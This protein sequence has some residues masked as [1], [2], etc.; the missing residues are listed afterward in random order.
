MFFG[1][2]L[3]KHDSFKNIL[4]IGYEFET[5]DLAKLSLSDG[6]LVNSSITARGM[7]KKI[8]YSSASKADDNNYELID[9]DRDLYYTEYYDEYDGV[10][11]DYVFMN[12]TNDVGSSN[13]DTM[14]NKLCKKYDDDSIKNDI[15]VFKSENG[16]IQH[17]I[18]FDSFLSNL[19][20]SIFS[21]V[22]YLVTYLKIKKTTN[23]ILET[24]LNACNRIFT[25][26]RGIKKIP[27]DLFM[28]DPENGNDIKIGHM[29]KRILYHKPNTNL[30]YLQTHDSDVFFKE[31]SIG[32]VQF[33]PQMTFR[34]NIKHVI[35]IMKDI[36]HNSDLNR[37]KRTKN[38][39]NREHNAISDIESCLESLF[40]TYNE[41][42]KTTK[43]KKISKVLKNQIFGYLF[44]IFYKIYMYINSYIHS[45]MTAD[46]NYF[47]NYLSFSA[48]HNNFMFYEKIKKLMYPSFKENTVSTI[49]ALLNQPK[50][51][52]KFIYTSRSIRNAL[53]TV[54]TLG[55]EEYG[56]PSV[57]YISYFHHF[58]KFSEEEENSFTDED[59]FIKADIDIYSTKFKMPEDGSIIIENRLFS[60]EL[61]AFANDNVNIYAS[62]AFSLNNLKNIY[63]KLINTHKVDDLSKKE[64][65]PNTL[66]FVNKCKSG[67]YRNDDFVCK[68]KKTTK[69]THTKK[70]PTK[71]TTTRKNIK[72]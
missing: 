27:G 68:P 4:S 56:N 64:I 42:T 8:K 3:N 17:N 58:E 57:S 51:V 1:G 44:M 12:I 59:W 45:D 22:E 16:E 65:N 25:H 30:Y 11:N 2:D 31:N 49:I 9:E 47:K 67:H 34:A 35:S 21:G 20:C 55:D 72:V 37:I 60:T 19:N 14:L 23:I 5:H 50:I 18:V 69:K 48:R 24:F 62:G 36:V 71:K 10:A 15:Y 6:V 61:T 28:R 70:N 13:F 33:Q 32:N 38:Q 63:R 26:I 52:G 29:D 7:T 43:N 66:N 40:E 46:D 39:L 41:N 54:L 53:K